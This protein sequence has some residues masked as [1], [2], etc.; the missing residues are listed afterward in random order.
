MKRRHLIV[1]SLLLLSVLAT[2]LPPKTD[3]E[4]CVQTSQCS[5]GEGWYSECIDATCQHKSIWPLRVREWLGVFLLFILLGLA[6]IGGIG[7]GGLIIPI[8]IACFGLST[9]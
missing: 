2:D 3:G 6:N 4:S 8:C 5:D 9:R 1:F 7:G